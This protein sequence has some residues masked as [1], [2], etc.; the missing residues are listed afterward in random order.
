MFV[1]LDQFTKHPHFR[2]KQKASV[3]L[4]NVEEDIASESDVASEHPN[5]VERLLALALAEKG[6]EDLGDRGRAGAG[7]RQRGKV[8]RTWP[9]LKTP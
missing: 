2:P 1:P 9:L 5:V 7:Q 8:D 3:L 4:F 6:R